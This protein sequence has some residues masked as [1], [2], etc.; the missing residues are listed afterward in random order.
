MLFVTNNAIV[1][2]VLLKNARFPPKCNGSFS[3]YRISSYP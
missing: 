2:L 1:T 3:M